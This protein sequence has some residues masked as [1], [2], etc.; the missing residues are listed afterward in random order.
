MIGSMVGFGTVTVGKY[1]DDTAAA[2]CHNVSSI[3]RILYLIPG[4]AVNSSQNTTP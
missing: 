1:A 4:T 2:C 3:G